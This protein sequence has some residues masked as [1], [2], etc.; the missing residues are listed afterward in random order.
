VSTANPVC[1][2]LYESSRRDEVVEA[3]QC[4]ITTVATTQSFNDAVNGILEICAEKLGYLYPTVALLDE[5]GGRLVGRVLVSP[6]L[7]RSFIEAVGNTGVPL[8]TF[9]GRRKERRATASRSYVSTNIPWD[10]ISYRLDC[11]ENAIVS[12][13]LRQGPHITT[14]FHDI[15]RP[16]IKASTASVIQ[17]I[18]GVD[19][20]AVLPLKSKERCLGVLTVASP[21]TRSFAKF[22]L[23]VLGLCAAQVVVAVQTMRLHQELQQREQQ[24][25]FLLARV[26]DAQEEERE[27]I[28]L[29][30]HD[31]VA[32]TLAPAFHYLQAM[33]THPECP[34]ALLA[35][36]RKV[37]TL[38]RTASREAREVV[39]SLRPASLDTLGLI[40]TLRYEIEELRMRANWQ[41]EFDPHQIRFP[42]AVET[43]L[44]RIVHEALNNVAKHARATRVTV[45]FRQEGD[46]VVVEIRDDGMGFNQIPLGSQLRRKGVG[47]LSMRKRTELMGGTFQIVSSPGRGTNVLI[48][49]PLAAGTS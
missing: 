34:E 16:D 24:V 11:V 49:I 35:S 6:H 21:K 14:R 28:C 44:Y 1:L 47:L 3:L 2:G 30:I 36:V 8:D 4:A 48:E 22:D 7:Q 26:I 25:N 17:E 40:Q 15:V 32:Q 12:V 9:L 37:G 42:R 27:R 39:A 31:G 19:S 29:E 13:V 5:S 18:L 45:Q 38:V 23:P 41:V 33:E 43:G 10:A 46:R 20:I